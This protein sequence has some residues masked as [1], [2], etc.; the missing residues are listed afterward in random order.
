M[1][2]I[3][4][5]YLSLLL[6]IGFYSFSCVAIIAQEDF[7]IEIEA[8]DIYGLPSLHSYAH[9]QWDNKW[10]IL[11]GQTS[12][13]WEFSHANLEIYVVDPIENK[14]WTMPSEYLYG[15]VKSIEQLTSC[16]SQ[17]YQ[18]G[19]QLYMLGGYGY[20]SEI[21]GYYAF[22]HLTI[23]NVQEVISHIIAKEY[24]IAATYFTQIEDDRFSVMDGLLTKIEHTFYLIGGIE[25]YGFFDEENPSYTKMPRKEILSFQIHKE[26]GNQ[27]SIESIGSIDYTAEFEELFSTSVPQI[28]KNEKEGF[29]IISNEDVDGEEYTSWMD[30]FKVGYA[31]SWKRDKKIPHY[32]STIIP[33]YDNKEKVMH[34]LFLNGCSD[35]SW[36]EDEVYDTIA[37]IDSLFI[38]SQS[39]KTIIMKEK[40][41][42][43]YTSY[44]KD[45][46][47]IANDNIPQYRN[48]VIKLHKLPKGKTQIGFIFGGSST[49]NPM[50][51]N[52]GSLIAISSSQLFK[53]SII[54]K[55]FNL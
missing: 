36:S 54:K 15:Q 42:M 44:G 25:F 4:N 53:V 2:I 34:T 11:G 27:Y 17:F 38:F 45:A 22:P 33:L 40:A 20:S 1:S 24:E 18:E 23:L 16:F 37:G 30:I 51:N 31:K 9:A 3:R 29:S 52:D 46:Q 12:E 28:Y 5:Y 50:I 32:H 55:D 41:I 7:Q 14:I 35:F 43:P 19:N 48:G 6:F 21:E 49:A 13:D 47:F 10:L 8:I 39:E 26:K